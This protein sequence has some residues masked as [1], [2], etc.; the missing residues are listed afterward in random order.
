[1]EKVL[2]LAVE[3]NGDHIGLVMIDKKVTKINF[4]AQTT[5]EGGPVNRRE[6]KLTANK[7]EIAKFEESFVG[8]MP[9]ANLRYHPEASQWV[10]FISY[11]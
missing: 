2:K 7:R 8:S 11:K 5:R 9:P 10:E 4:A 1:M 3:D 6:V